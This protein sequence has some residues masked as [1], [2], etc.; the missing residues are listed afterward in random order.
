[1]KPILILLLW[2]FAPASGQAPVTVQ[3]GASYCA[4]LPRGAQVQTYC[5]AWPGP[6]WVLVHN[7]IDSIPASGEMSTSWWSGSDVIVW[8]FNSSGGY[9]YT[10]DRNSTIVNGTFGGTQAKVEM[11]ISM[12]CGTPIAPGQQQTC[13]ITL[14]QAP[15]AD[16]YFS[17]NVPAPL[18]G[19]AFALVVAGDTKVSF[20]ITLPAGTPIASLP[21]FAAPWAVW[22][23]NGPREWHADVLIPCCAE[24]NL[25]GYALSEVSPEPCA[26]V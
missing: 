19:P 6:P 3:F 20:Q 22:V 25:C 9:S 17:V 13:T 5:Y 23:L 12:S 18:V 24:A 7:Q 2:A 15:L 16:Y 21:Y 4:A 11:T 8:K 14:N 10:T 1:M 26:G